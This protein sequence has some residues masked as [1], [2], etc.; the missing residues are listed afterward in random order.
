[1]LRSK[2]G[3]RDS[4]NS[5]DWFNL[6]DFTYESNGWGHGLP[7]ADK[8]LNTWDIWRPLLGDTALR[9]ARTD[10]LRTVEHMRE[11]IAIRR[12]VALFRL[13]TAEDVLQVVGFP[14]QGV[15]QTPGVIVM[16]LDDT[17]ANIDPTYAY[18]VVIFNATREAQTITVEPA[19][20]QAL[21][22]HPIFAAS[23]DPIVG[24]SSFDSATGTFTIPALTTAVFVAEDA[25]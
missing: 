25:G 1:M 24:E 17:T 18:A 20:G 13:R 15:D 2:S 5:S 8:N 19:V 22:L 9:P 10:I 16:T 12:D 11:A 6:L 21:A 23:S 14:D 3:D 7:P 4:F